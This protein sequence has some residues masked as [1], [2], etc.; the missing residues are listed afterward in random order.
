[1]ITARWLP[2]SR[3][4]AICRTLLGVLVFVVGCTG[5]GGGDREVTG[6]AAFA[7]T[8]NAVA[9]EISGLPQT[10]SAGATGSMTVRAV[11]A[12]GS[13][14][15]GYTGTV[16]FAA[17]S[18]STTFPPNYTF[19]EGD[20]GVRTFSFTPIQA[21]LQI[22]YATDTEVP[23]LTGYG[24]VPVVPG[25]IATFYLDNLTH[26]LPLTAGV[27]AHFDVA[28]YDSHWNI[29][30]TY[31]GPAI[32]TS[33][34]PLAILP[35]SPTFTNGAATSV[36]ITL[37]TPGY[38]TVE[39]H[40]AA[41]PQ[42]SWTSWA[43]VNPGESQIPTPLTPTISAPDAVTTGVTG[44]ASVLARSGMTYAWGITGG[45]ITSAGG[46]AGVMGGGRNTISYMPGDPGTLGLSCVES[47]GTDVSAPG[48]ESL[49][50]VAAPVTPVITTASSVTAGQMGVTATVPA[51]AGMTYGW[52]V[53]GAT[54][55]S[56]G[57]TAGVT[58]GG[59]NGIT[60]TAGLWN[61]VSLECYEVNAAGAVS[62]PASALLPIS[63]SASF[64][65][66]LY[67]AAHQ[68]DDLLFMN[69]DLERSIQWGFPTQT[70]FLTAGDDGSCPACWHARENGAK[71]AHAAMAG[72]P[73]NWSCSPRTFQ[74]KTATL[75]ALASAPSVSLLFLRLPDGALSQLWSTQFGP[76]F[77]TTPVASLTAV[78]QAYS[79]TR[80]ELVTLIGDVLQDTSPARIN[81]LDATLAYGPDHPDH[82]ASGLF[83]LLGAEGYALP[84]EHRMFRAYNVFGNWF[85]VPSP[86]PENLS[87]SEY[88]EK[89]SVMG[90]YAGG[91][92]VDS[93]FDHWCHRRYAIS[94]L[95]SGTGPLVTPSGACL[96]T[97]D[98]SGAN[99]ASVVTAACSG[100]PSQKW[101]VAADGTL[102]GAAGRCLT[103]AGGGAAEIADCAGAP[104]QRFEL[105]TN[106]QLRASE[107][108]CLTVSWSG[109]VSA[110]LCDAD[111][112]TVKYV[113]LPS[114]RF[115]LQFSAPSSWT[116]NGD[117]SDAV[118]GGAE[119]YYRTFALA[120]ANADRFADACV[121]RADG[122]C[123]ALGGPGGFGACAL[124]APAFSDAAG[125]L[126]A[127]YGTT[128]QLADVN[129]D[130]IA[131]ACGRNAAG[132]ACAL[133]PA[134]G[135]SLGP[136]A[137]WSSDFGD[138]TFG[139]AAYY[140]SLRFG[141]IDGDGF[142]DVC[143]RASAGIACA[144]NTGAGAF[145]PATTWLAGDFDDAGGW[146]AASQ[147]GTLRL[148]DIDGDHTADV[149]LRGAAGLRCATSNGTA[150]TN[151]HLWSFRSDFGDAAGW[152]AAPARHGSIRLADVNGDGLAD[153]C[154]R[155]PDGLVCGVSNGAGFEAAALV[156]PL[157]FT[158]E[159]G[160]DEAPY[161][162]TLQLADLNGD[163]RADV[164]G[165]S[166][167]GLTCSLSP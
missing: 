12:D 68:D 63:G 45:A 25:P 116:A 14:A 27:Q 140:P 51:Q 143:G 158:D 5:E 52:S 130:G 88:T 26:G 128:V 136:L 35:P 7:A 153:A 95:R 40:D 123:C 142:A 10:L 28:A 34:D 154:G 164:C 65:A 129:G 87:P 11:A 109:S 17:N 41:Q 93:D 98:G 62:A 146:N 91:F 80:A 141:D 70:V 31:Q 148:A 85:D 131:D 159:L 21:V 103:I 36:P 56:P 119:S 114:Q 162:T 3:W 124:V 155:G 4:L 101:T 23:S 74:G 112:S 54:I 83:V 42:V 107:G 76:P 79:V 6:R 33:S 160:W 49:S 84:A 24:T 90:A 18:W 108:A 147:T 126:P 81:T 8:A 89:V 13:T 99:G 46:P 67:F 9:L 135:G 96:D 122:L 115:T 57:G 97:E 1:M 132:I 22:L 165:R 139:G 111:R 32:V 86:E 152:G 106:G 77:W 48:T 92:E 20:Q 110:A 105:F 43:L 157:G 121:R 19:Q 167:Q 66:H 127:P 78:D 94:R 64:S 134:G 102:T 149:C 72:V 100:A 137:Q 161:G 2:T 118:A 163:G 151:A 120:R 156:Q 15:T 145:A 117:F 39:I 61:Q 50:V 133:A 59:T 38:A 30:T 53:S 150:F 16:H 58:A 144:R 166:P 82:V 44:S 138:A 104:A 60:F 75:C 125:W 69:P 73:S 29:V 113:P 71:N 47:N 37:M 55:T